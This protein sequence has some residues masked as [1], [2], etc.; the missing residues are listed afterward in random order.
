MYPR[1]TKA[2]WLGAIDIPLSYGV[3][4]RITGARSFPE[5]RNTLAAR[6]T[7]SRIGII[8]WS[9]GPAANAALQDAARRQTRTRD[10][11]TTGRN[12]PPDGA[13]ECA[14]LPAGQWRRP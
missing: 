9:R 12:L 7:P 6:R 8:T 5:G 11:N 13:P 2:W 3:R 10:S 14:P 1:S 4:S